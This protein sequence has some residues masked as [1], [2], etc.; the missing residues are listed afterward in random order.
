MFQK[1][2]SG[3]GFSVKKTF[4]G[5]FIVGG[6]HTDGGGWEDFGVFKL[7]SNGSMQWNKQFDSG[8]ELDEL[9]DI[10]QTSD[11]GYAFIGEVQFYSSMNVYVY[12]MK[13][14]SSGDTTWTKLYN[15]SGGEPGY[16]IKQT[17]DGGFILSGATEDSTDSSLDGYLIKIDGM[18][19]L[20]WSRSYSDSGIY[21][22][23]FGS[24]EITSAG[25]FL[26]A[27]YY[28]SATG[29]GSAL[30][31]TDSLGNLRWA[32][33]YNTPFGTVN[34]NSIKE[35]INGD[36]LLC[37]S[38]T[39]FGAGNQDALLIQLD[40]S[41][42][43]LWARTYGGTYAEYGNYAIQSFD[44]GY[45]MAGITYSFSPD[46]TSDAFIL[47]TDSDGTLVWSKSYGGI[48]DD[49]AWCLQQTNDS[50]FIISGAT[51]GLGN[52]GYIIKTDSLGNSGCNEQVPPLISFQVQLT[53]TNPVVLVNTPA[54]FAISTNTTVLSAGSIN[55]LC[56]TNVSDLSS[57]VTLNISPNPFHSSAILKIENF[58]SSIN[59]C[60]LRIYNVMGI[61]MRE[62][63]I[64]NLNSYTLHRGSLS[65]GMYFFEL[66][67]NNSELLGTGKFIVE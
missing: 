28:Y 24:V 35:L 34:T 31:K 20:E 40:T 67:I 37:S 57:Q 58:S 42:T 5:G 12:A 11:G 55:Q 7:D 30:F 36:Y 17:S 49:Y 23:L 4:D 25:E 50:G 62:E 38:T 63:K 1:V 8:A 59:N 29:F 43:P 6:S 44:G 21:D 10:I 9:F 60:E 53:T 33:N 26:I 16:S 51:F 18:G 3:E 22:I 54:S 52:G 46:S 14:N 61:L 65:D 41:G 66:R 48:W 27:G 2:I 32:R 15:V 47:K 39:N 13:L 56:S 64:S 45:V 19:N